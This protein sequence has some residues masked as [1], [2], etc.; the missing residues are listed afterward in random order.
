MI[1][2]NIWNYIK[3]FKFQSLLIKNFVLIFLCISIPVIII[4]FS[5]KNKYNDAVIQE[6]E[7]ANYNSVLRMQETVDRA[8]QEATRLT[9]HISISNGYNIFFDSDENYAN[10]DNSIAIIHERTSGYINIYDYI[11][12]IYLHSMK[13]NK[14]LYG[15]I[16]YLIGEVGI[17]DTTI[18]DENWYEEDINNPQLI[19]RYFSW[20]ENREGENH[21]NYV[22][23][24]H[25]VRKKRTE[26]LGSVTVNLKASYL[27]KMTNM[28]FVENDMSTL[29]IDNNTRQVIIS[30]NSDDFLKD[31]KDIEIF[32]EIKYKDFEGSDIVTIDK[33]EYIVTV[34]DSKYLD[35]TYLAM[36][37]LTSYSNDV[38]K[39][40]TYVK[41]NLLL[42]FIL[43]LILSYM[44]TLKT[45]A[46]VRTIMR[47]I[48]NPRLWDSKKKKNEN[49]VKYIS[50]NIF[51][52]ILSNETLE[53]EL[54]NKIS[55]LDKAQNKALQSQMNPHFLYN[56]LEAIN[57]TTID[58]T[59]GQNDASDMITQLSD[60]LRYSLDGE[61]FASLEDEV[62][63]CKTY[64]EI[65]KTRYKD[66][67]EAEWLIQEDIKACKIMKLTL[68]PIIENAIYHGIKPK[69]MK[70]VIHISCEL[71]SE[72]LM[73]IVTDNGV[74]MSKDEVTK[75]NSKINNKYL[76]KKE[77]I[78]MYNVNQRLKILYG[79][80]YGIKVVS[81]RDKGTSVI[82][83]LP[84]DN[85]ANK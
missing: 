26:I 56:T 53:Y 34:V 38:N 3:S 61:Q 57:W 83:K 42:S 23:V 22:T 32:S 80:V 24:V 15:N 64:I 74:G 52:I 72:T 13:L 69:R 60:M 39:I 54:R 6:I 21:R 9:A 50:N 70:G 8:M 44:L 63:C 46:P 1:K 76:L 28:P 48:E 30:Q 71:H 5:V 35:W 4:T 58:L 77:G 2:I 78:G 68:Q 18:V 20:Q 14:T 55:L 10:Y 49:E 11:S 29:V 85:L 43:S 33:I 67:I 41:R 45:Y 59:N 36:L 84:V 81:E 40:N 65:M 51:Q 73:I 25:Y 12:S 19:N 62:E 47:I 27:A 37:P 31:V 7:T 75:I 79:D 66:K 82:I 16:D 17:D